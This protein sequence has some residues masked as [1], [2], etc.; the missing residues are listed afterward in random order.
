[1]FMGNL[2]LKVIRKALYNKS[3]F[4]INSDQPEQLHP[5]HDIKLYLQ[6]DN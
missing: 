5:G 2:Q 4:G 1:M 3:C 6:P